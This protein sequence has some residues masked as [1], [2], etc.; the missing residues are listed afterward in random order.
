MSSGA[1]Y[2]TAVAETVDGEEMLMGR[3]GI[4]G[5]IVG[6]PATVV[7]P[8]GRRCAGAGGLGFCPVRLGAKA[9]AADHPVST[10]GIG[11]VQRE[12]TNDGCNG[13]YW[14]SYEQG[15][16]DGE[17]PAVAFVPE[18]DFDVCSPTNSPPFPPPDPSE[19]TLPRLVLAALRCA[20]PVSTI[21]TAGVCVCSGGFD[22]CAGVGV[23]EEKLSVAPDE[24]WIPP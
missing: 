14:A 17:I 15:T 22:N 16:G 13:Q 1:A 12:G 10:T 2:T 5:T 24:N 3:G 9:S 7:A 23:D 11:R 4:P 20:F 6:E 19:L 18:P 8:I 21:L